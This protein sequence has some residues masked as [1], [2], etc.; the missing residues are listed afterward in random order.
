[1]AI[2]PELRVLYT[3][4]TRLNADMTNLFVP[5]GQFLQKPY[6]SDQLEVSVRRL[7]TRLPSDRDALGTVA[8]VHQS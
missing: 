4:G 1:V 7:L 2:R 5:G 3:S 6:S 8:I